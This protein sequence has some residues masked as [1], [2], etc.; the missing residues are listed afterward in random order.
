MKISAVKIRKLFSENEDLYEKIVV[1]SKR[2][3]QI[4]ESRVVQLEAF[5]E[6]EDTDQLEQYD[7]IDHNVE[8][9]IS[10]A[11]S[12]LFENELEWSYEKEE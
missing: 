3:R 7:D 8:K 6:I 11:M 12:Q 5:E 10:I 1:A 9:P 2:H 4:V